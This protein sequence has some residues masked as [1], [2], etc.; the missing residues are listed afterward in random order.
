MGGSSST[1]TNEPWKPVQGPLE[2]IY[3]ST[4]NMWQAGAGPQVF[5][6]DTLAP[7]SQPTQAGL[8]QGTNLATSGQG[9]GQNLTDAYRN[10]VNMGG[11]NQPMLE[12]AQGMSELEWCG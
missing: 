9:I 11:F 3:K 5:P 1:T 8:L 4:D 10:S 7:W 12:G 2:D 6:G